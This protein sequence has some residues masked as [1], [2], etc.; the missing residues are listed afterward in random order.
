MWSI[1]QN[2][3]DLINMYVFNTSPLEVL[4]SKQ[5]KC[6]VKPN[7]FFFFQIFPLHSASLCN[8]LET[9][10][11][12]P[13]M[14]PSVALFLQAKFSFFEG[15]AHIFPTMSNFPCFPKADLDSSLSW[16]YCTWYHGV[17]QLI[18]LAKWL[19]TDQINLCSQKTRY[20]YQL[21]GLWLGHAS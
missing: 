13:F 19:Y 11:M 15:T 12:I 10:Q 8:Q 18:C 7:A 14:L 1:F 3:V 17:L 9:E 2:G 6:F 16:H 5:K 4:L 20:K 21:Y